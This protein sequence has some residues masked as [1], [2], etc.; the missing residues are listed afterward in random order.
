MYVDVLKRDA[1]FLDNIGVTKLYLSN[2][3]FFV[4]LLYVFVRLSSNFCNFYV[5]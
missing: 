3:S 5:M 1:V 4:Y 2:K